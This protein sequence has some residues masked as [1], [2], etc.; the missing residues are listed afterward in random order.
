L[1][2]KSTHPRTFAVARGD[3]IW[4]IA[5]SVTAMRSGFV[6]VADEDPLIIGAVVDGIGPSQFPRPWRLVDARRDLRNHENL[7][8]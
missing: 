6:Q 8:S 5:T 1:P 2:N 7:L 3:R 4:A